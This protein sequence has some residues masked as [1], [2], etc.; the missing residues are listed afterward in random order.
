MNIEIDIEYILKVIKVFSQLFINILP[1]YIC[2][3]RFCL[4][5]TDGNKNTCLARIGTSG[6]DS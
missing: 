1:S 6:G 2:K 4:T 5:C 3:K